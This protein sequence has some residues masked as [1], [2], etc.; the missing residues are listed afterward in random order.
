M[1]NKGMTLNEYQQ[2]AMTTC[3]DTSRN[4]LYM[5]FMLGE[6]IGEL[7]GKFSKAIRKGKI[8]FEN[9]ELVFTSKATKEEIVEFEDLIAKEC[10]DILWGIA[11]ICEVIGWKLNHIGDG[12][13]AKLA[14]RKAIGT[15]DGNGDGIVRGK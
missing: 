11:G 3:M 1:E 5:L 13:L 10:G 9:N 2:K 14:A 4:P 7:Q 8:K 6:E 15:I 12:N